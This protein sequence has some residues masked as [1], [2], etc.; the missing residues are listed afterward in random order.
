V[1]AV[2]YYYALRSSG[3]RTAENLF[4][5]LSARTSDEH[6][7]STMACIGPEYAALHGLTV[8][9][10]G[11]TYQHGGASNIDKKLEIA[12]SYQRL[13]ETNGGNR[14]LLTQVASACSVSRNFVRKIEKELEA[15]GR[16]L[17]PKEL[18]QDRRV[19]PG[20]RT[21]DEME[22]FVLLLLLC[23][24]IVLQ[25]AM[26]STIHNSHTHSSHILL[27]IVLFLFI[28]LFIFLFMTDL[29]KEI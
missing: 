27:L 7:K 24:F 20:A 18:K 17:H 2:Y 11:G 29:C 22:A 13:R 1:V 23:Y 16:V 25:Y 10:N 21:L 5:F 14:A 3:T 4:F 9:K 28:F 15:H 12:V 26:Y 6:K 19:G 8:N